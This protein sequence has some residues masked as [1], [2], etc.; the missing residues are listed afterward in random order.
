MEGRLCGDRRRDNRTPPQ[1]CRKHFTGKNMMKNLIRAE[2]NKRKDHSPGFHCLRHSPCATAEASSI[3]YRRIIR[4]TL[5]ELLV[6]IAII[7]ILVA[8]LL[9]SLR[10]AK[11]MAQKIVCLNNLRQMGTGLAMYV[12]DNHNFMPRRGATFYEI[13]YVGVLAGVGFYTAQHGELYPD[14]IST[15]EVY[16]CPLNKGNGMHYFKYHSSYWYHLAP[17]AG[18]N[19]RY[20]NLKVGGVEYTPAGLS[21]LCEGWG[22]DPNYN[23]WFKYWWPYHQLKN[24]REYSVLFYDGHVKAVSDH[25]RFVN[26]ENNA[27]LYFRNNY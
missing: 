5:I 26:S 6:V 23:I 16:Y 22:N 19:L 21:I 4:F 9:P 25:N 11:V 7:A 1:L 18:N 8:L 2:R 10:A 13:R 12:Q 24:P 20:T 3:K 17:S 27:R 14:Y 15:G